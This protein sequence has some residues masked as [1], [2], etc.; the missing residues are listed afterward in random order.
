MVFVGTH[1]SRFVRTALVDDLGALIVRTY[2][3]DGAVR[4]VRRETRDVEFAPVDVGDAVRR[5]R[6]ERASVR[7]ARRDTTRGRTNP[8][9]LKTSDRAR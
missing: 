9:G 4:A 1:A 6:A 3:C 7:A 2:L 8:R 5:V